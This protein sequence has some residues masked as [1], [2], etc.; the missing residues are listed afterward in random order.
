[1]QTLIDVPKN[2]KKSKQE[3]DYLKWYCNMGTMENRC[4]Y[5]SCKSRE[6][7]LIPTFEEIFD[8]M[9][10]AHNLLSHPRDYKKNEAELDRTYYSI[11]EQCIKLF[12]KLCPPCFPCRKRTAKSRAPLRMILSPTFGHRAQIDLIDMQTKAIHGYKYILRYVGHLSGFAHVACCCTK[13]AQEVGLKLIHILSTTITPEIL[14]SDNGSE[15][16]GDC[17]KAIKA[18]YGYIHIVKGR[19]YH[20]QTQGKIEWGH[21]SFKKALQK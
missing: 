19:T 17:I 7:L 5:R 13:S 3:R 6:P 14:Q 18:F 8:I 2:K 4:L 15:F 1:M 20:P 16:V 11:P 10:K 12:L 21:A 9:C